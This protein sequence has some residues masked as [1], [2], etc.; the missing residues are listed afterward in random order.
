MLG[1]RF[2]LHDV[3]IG[4]G[5]ATQNSQDLENGAHTLPNVFQNALLLQEFCV[6]GNLV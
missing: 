2:V 5:K 3:G 4:P 1:E 6:L